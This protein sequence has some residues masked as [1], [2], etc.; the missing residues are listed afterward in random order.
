MTDTFRTYMVTAA[1]QAAAQALAE[2]YEGGG[3]MFIVGIGANEKA[4]ATEFI[5]TGKLGAEL[6][7]AL[8]E[9]GLLHD[10]SEEEPKAAM[11]RLGLQ[12]VQGDDV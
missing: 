9:S 4:A 5:S 11:G 1:N 12:I 8:E 2:Q 10:I 6:A 3:G 7:T